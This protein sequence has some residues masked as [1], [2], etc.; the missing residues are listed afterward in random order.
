MSIG[1]V[2]AGDV[3]GLVRQDANN[4]VGVLRFEDEARVDEDVLPAG[5]KGVNRWI[6]DN[7]D[8]DVSGIE[9]RRLEQ[10]IGVD[11]QRVLDLR[12]ADQ[13]LRCGGAG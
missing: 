4:L 3:A 1:M 8:V 9:A 13:R 7:I 10:R 12:V 2:S 6:V 5:D 11:A